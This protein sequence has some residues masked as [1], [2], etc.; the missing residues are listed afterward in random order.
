MWFLRTFSCSNF[1][2]KFEANEDYDMTDVDD[3]SPS[4][5]AA[6]NKRQLSCNELFSSYSAVSSPFLKAIYVMFV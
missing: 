6:K 5:L 2:V 3:I 1:S 4:R